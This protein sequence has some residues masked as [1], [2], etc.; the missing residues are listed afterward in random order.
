[1]DTTCFL[2]KFSIQATLL[3]FSV[4]AFSIHA[5]PESALN[6]R[7]VKHPGDLRNVYD[8]IIVGGGTAGLTIADRLT[9][10]TKC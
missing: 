3:I 1:M 6:A 8:I 5:I 2:S 7:H 9:E 4:L 10:S